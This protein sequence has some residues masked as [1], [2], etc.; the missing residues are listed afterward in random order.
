VVCCGYKSSARQR[1]CKLCALF[2]VVL[3]ALSYLL[4]RVYL[5]LPVHRPPKVPYLCAS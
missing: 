1:I 4:R 3:R 2:F 5:A